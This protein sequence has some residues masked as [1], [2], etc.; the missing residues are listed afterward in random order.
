MRVIDVSTLLSAAVAPIVNILVPFVFRLEV[1]NPIPGFM[2]ATPTP[3][4]SIGVTPADFRWLVLTWL[5]RLV[6]KSGFSRGVLFP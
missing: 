6:A 1:N 4:K 5:L 3:I 2:I